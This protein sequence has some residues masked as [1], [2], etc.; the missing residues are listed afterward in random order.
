MIGTMP[1]YSHLARAVQRR[2]RELGY[3]QEDLILVTGLGRT[4]V[5]RIWGGTVLHEPTAKT[6]RLLE[7]SL[8]W[9]P[10]SVDALL[11][12]G[13]ATPRQSA[14]AA[15]A[16]EGADGESETPGENLPLAV[17]I[18]L[19]FGR[20]LDYDVYTTDVDGDPMQMI[21]IAVT[22]AQAVD[23]L[24]KQLERFGEIKG[25]VRRHVEGETGADGDSADE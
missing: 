6:K 8:R 18:A 23:A 20:L 17:Q 4:T 21:Q 24:K 11:A 10:G 5:Q 3:N 22:N 14:S 2:A 7:A 12:G 9:E 16:P 19:E 1:D 13:E 15:E 25:Y